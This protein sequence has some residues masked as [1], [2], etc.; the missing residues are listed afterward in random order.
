MS[1]SA[2]EGFVTRTMLQ[3]L[4]RRT[5]RGSQSVHRVDLTPATSYSYAEAGSAWNPLPGRPQQNAP[6]A[7]PMSD[8]F[9][10]RSLP[11]LPSVVPG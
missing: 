2:R 6:G 10:A 11:V 5:E 1:V 4:T 7:S 3:R 8:R 9:A